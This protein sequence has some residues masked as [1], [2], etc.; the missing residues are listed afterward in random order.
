[1]LMLFMLDWSPH[2][3]LIDTLL[4]NKYVYTYMNKNTAKVNYRVEGF[5]LLAVFVV[6]IVRS[7][8]NMYKLAKEKPKKANEEGQTK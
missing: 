2:V 5:M 8:L 3:N 6:R 1:M 4:G 7:L